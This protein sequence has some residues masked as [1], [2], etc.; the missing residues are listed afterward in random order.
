MKIMK[1]ILPEPPLA[2]TVSLPPPDLRIQLAMDG[3]GRR[4]RLQAT[5]A[6]GEAW[7]AAIPG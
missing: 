4:A 7:L 5:S 2:A 6:R 1:V 3:A